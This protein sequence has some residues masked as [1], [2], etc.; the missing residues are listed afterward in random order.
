[1]YQCNNDAIANFMKIGSHVLK[2][3][4]VAYG[5]RHEYVTLHLSVNYNTVSLKCIK[6]LLQ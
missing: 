6:I 2:K 4:C 5:H 1:M 3:F